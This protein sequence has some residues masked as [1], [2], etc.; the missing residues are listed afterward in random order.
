VAR[1]VAPRPCVAIGG[2]RAGNAGDCV[3]AGA[4]AVSAISAVAGAADMQ[5]AARA[6]ARA[7]Q[8]GER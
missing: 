2:I 8:P 3:R 4:A 5:A 7:A 1:L 6:L